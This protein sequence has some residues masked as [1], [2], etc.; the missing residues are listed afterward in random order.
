MSAAGW[1]QADPWGGMRAADG[2]CVMLRAY[3]P[4]LTATPGA[5]AAGR[6][7]HGPARAALEQDGP[8]RMTGRAAHATWAAERAHEPGCRCPNGMA[9]DSGSVLR[10][11]AAGVEIG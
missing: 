2:R 4:A 6:G 1:H 3:E 8:V 10:L 11:F 9:A 5:E 7:R